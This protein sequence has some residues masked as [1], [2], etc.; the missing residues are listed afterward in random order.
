[1]GYKNRRFKCS[2]CNEANIAQY[3]LNN[4]NN[5]YYSCKKCVIENNK[6]NYIFSNIGFTKYASYVP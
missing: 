4:D 6:E 2:N 3:L 1:M 5:K